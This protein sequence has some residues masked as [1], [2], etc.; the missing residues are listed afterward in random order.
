MF[1]VVK[2]SQPPWGAFNSMRMNATK[3]ETR[4]K[5]KIMVGGGAISQE[6]AASIGADGYDPTAPGAVNLARKF[7]G[8]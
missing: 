4:Q 5:V 1:Q 2:A 8:K 3:V 7:V 6:F